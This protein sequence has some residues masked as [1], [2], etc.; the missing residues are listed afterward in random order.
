MGRRKSSASSTSS[1]ILVLRQAQEA[2]GDAC[3]LYF[4][5]LAFVCAGHE[6]FKRFWDARKNRNMEYQTSDELNELVQWFRAR[7]NEVYEKAEWAKARSAEQLPYVDRLVHDRARDIVSD[8][9]C[10][11]LSSRQ[12]RQ[13]A[14][15]ELLGDL[16]NAEEGYETAMWLLSTLL[17]DVM[18]DGVKLRDDDRAGYERLI[19]PL[20]ERLDGVRRKM[21]A[22]ARP[23]S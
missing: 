16:P 23:S 3:A 15:A 18:H 21:D 17:D 6:R 10:W 7:F 1:D 20:R 12:S 13:S 5:S 19:T 2:A 22:A 9:A 8:L 11:N 4:K 14:Q